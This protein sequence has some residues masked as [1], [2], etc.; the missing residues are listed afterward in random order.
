MRTYE[1]HLAAVR[2]ALPQPR[3]VSTPLNSAFGRRAAAT[4]R[5]EHN[6]PPFD[7]SQMDGYALPTT[8]GGTFTVGRTIAAGDP[9][10]SLEQGTALPIM[11]GAKIPEGT[12]TIVPVEHC[13]PPR[14][15]EEGATVTVPAAP[16]QFI[17]RAGSDVKAGTTLINEHALLD[18]PSIATLASQGLTEVLTVAPARILICTG[19]AEIGG[20]GGATIPD[21]NAPMLAALARQYGIDV[22][23][24]VRTND[25]P[26][27]LRADLAEA[28]ITHRPDVIV[29]SGGISHGKFEVIRQIFE[30]DGWFG[31]VAQ[32]PGGPQGLSRLGDVPVVCFPGNPIS[33]LV[34]FRLYLA[35]VL[36]HAS[37]P[38]R[39]HLVESADGLNNRE[40]FRRG[41][42]SISDGTAHASFLG[43][44]SSH[45]MSQAI[46]A[47][48]LIRIPANTQLS[49]GDLVEV[50]PL[51]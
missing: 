1:E 39:A 45:L 29:T 40:Q 10:G 28:V 18:A 11:T 35:P 16:E 22:A 6:L 31:H 51:S 48:A 33:T 2:A 44:T 14:F 23:G 27:A 3:V 37:E 26:S 50:F 43:G 12:V 13:E 42:I 46:G 47:N 34:S 7:N 41:T 32:Q 8:D 9:P 30:E 36:G 24:F 17:R 19:G 20:E 4:Y 5:A 21:S 38:V 15:P 49:A 25:D